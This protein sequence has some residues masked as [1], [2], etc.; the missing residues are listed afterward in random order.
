[1]LKCYINSNKLIVRKIRST[2]SNSSQSLNVSK[3]PHLT[4]LNLPAVDVSHFPFSRPAKRRDAEKY[5]T[6]I[7]C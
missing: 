5:A 6:L 2:F 3:L 4:V 7:D 1:M